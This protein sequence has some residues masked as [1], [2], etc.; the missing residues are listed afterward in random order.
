[1][2]IIFDIWNAVIIDPMVNSL[3]LLYSIFFN[4]FGVSI[5]IFTVMMRG[6]MF[7]LTV[8]Q[9]RQ[10]KKM[11][12][13]QPK[14]KE[15]QE[16]Y[17]K[18]RQKISSET[19]KIYKENGVNP[20]GCL[21]P[22]FLQFP[23]WIGLYRSIL[24]ILPASPDSL[25]GLSGHLYSWLPRVHEVIPLNSQF[26]W[27]DL[28]LPDPIALPIMVGASMYLMQ[29]MTVMPS[30]DPRQASTNRM[31]L[32][33]MPLMFGFFTTSFP[34]GLALYWIVSNIVG[35]IIQGFITGWEPLTSLLSFRRTP[36]EGEQQATGSAT[37]LAPP[38]EETAND[39]ND[40]NNSQNDGRSNRN[41]PKG[42]RRRTRGSRNRR[43]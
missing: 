2:E 12:E 14:V 35:V 24:Q 32:W 34:S 10:M 42:A 28:A 21:G 23:I 15:M 6:V 3:V 13:I 18:D 7:P 11:T 43:R 37:A 31:M 41:R 20:I 39:E 36:K 5:L 29:K 30:A 40:R 38:A 1:M 22:M 4:N 25:V 9:S 33:M 16:R 17:G 27:L 19:M 8:R 26:L